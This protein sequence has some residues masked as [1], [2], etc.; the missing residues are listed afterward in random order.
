MI[1]EAIREYYLSRLIIKSA[2]RKPKAGRELMESSGNRQENGIVV[3]ISWE[4][5]GSK[6]KSQPD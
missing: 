6:Q 4:R 5:F 2:K 1:G 3:K